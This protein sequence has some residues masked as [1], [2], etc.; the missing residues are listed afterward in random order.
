M[1]DWRKQSNINDLPLLFEK[2]RLMSLQQDFSRVTLLIFE[3]YLCLF[4]KI[5]FALICSFGN[6]LIGTPSGPKAPR[7]I[8][9]AQV[10]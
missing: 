8:Y 10:E 7:T 5:S 6:K 9:R 4:C 3:P 1:F 2:I